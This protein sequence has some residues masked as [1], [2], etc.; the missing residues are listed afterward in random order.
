MSLDD[1]NDRSQGGVPKWIFGAIGPLL[2]TL[3]GIVIIAR[4]HITIPTRQAGA[5]EFHDG[6][7][8]AWGLLVIATASAG[9]FHYFWGNA[10]SLAPYADLGK[11]ASLGVLVLCAAFLFYRVFVA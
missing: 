11:V 2:G 5:A 4:G 8:T 10:D 9:H 6:D 3:V 7:A 1:L